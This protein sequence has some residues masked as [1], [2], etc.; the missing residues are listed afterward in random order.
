MQTQEDYFPVAKGQTWKHMM[1]TRLSSQQ[2]SE[3]IDTHDNYNALL[4]VVTHVC[5]L[6]N[7]CIG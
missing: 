2:Y 7:T 6:R 3:L 4:P 1:G 5:I